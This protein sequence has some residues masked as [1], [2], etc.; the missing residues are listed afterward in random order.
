MGG[1]KSAHNQWWCVQ[2]AK[3]VGSEP[4]A[5]A[6]GFLRRERRSFVEQ[7]PENKVVIDASVDHEVVDNHRERS[8]RRKRRS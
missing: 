6:R 8:R 4:P 7:L 5:N 3:G 2:G 1:T